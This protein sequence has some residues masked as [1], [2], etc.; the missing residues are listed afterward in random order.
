MSRNT[1]LRS[2]KTLKLDRALSGGMGRQILIYAIVVIATFSL[3][4]GIAI[5]IGIPV[6]EKTEKFGDFWKMLFYFYDGGL[7]GTGEKKWF[8]YLVNII[9]SILMGG[10]LIATITN[11]LLSNRD[12]AEM[13]LLRYRLSGHSAFIGC[14][15]SSIPLVKRVIKQHKYAVII[16]ELPVSEAKDKVISGLESDDL[17]KQ[18]ELR[19]QILELDKKLND[20][21]MMAKED[22]EDLKKRREDCKEELRTC[23]MEFQALEDAISSRLIVYHGLRTDFDE[24]KSL[25]LDDAE[26]VFVFPDSTLSNT[27][28]TNLEVVERLSLLCEGRGDKL[29]C[30]ALF[31]HNAVVSCFERSDINAQIK[32]RL[33]FSPVVYGDA[34]SRALLSGKVYGNQPLDRDGITEDSDQ[35]VHLFIIG[36]G[37]IG[38]A[39]FSE[40]VRQLHFPNFDKEKSTITLVGEQTE[41]DTAKR[42]YREYFALADHSPRYSYLGDILDIS[43]QMIPLGNPQELDSA[44]DRAIDNPDKLVTVAVCLEDSAMALEQTVSLSRCVFE[45]AIPIW[46]YKTD[47]D[48]LAKL[49]GENSFYS[50]IHLFGEPDKLFENDEREL[51]L[52]RAKR[53]NL[54]YKHIYDSLKKNKTLP[55]TLPEGLADTG[56][57]DTEWAGL[58]FRKQM[59]NL[60]CAYFI[61]VTERARGTGGEEVVLTDEQIDL[62]SRV[63]HNRWMA[64]TLISGFR[65]PFSEE[66][67]R[68]KKERSKEKFKKEKYVHL[69]LCS[70]EDLLPNDDG[71]DVREFDRGTVI[72]FHLIY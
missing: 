65:P 44:L 36:L 38:Q 27:D 3:L 64:E 37:E 70:S 52:R 33:D 8:I 6:S 29:K 39:L 2:T 41:I 31:Q 42:R 54:V 26:E 15:D 51:A 1:H 71:I 50:N 16:S 25:C 24:L 62:F 47:S 46:L 18:I 67:E 32:N 10:I 66:K 5:I 19:K 21:A 43:V 13:G 11:F 53:I 14:H 17:K 56:V 22:P 35:S 23:E 69:D 57:L 28:S 30:T 72:F 7:E 58:S 59:S 40:A 45:K 20:P 49:I 9:G 12:K 34:I 63:E 55:D 48:S 61:P 68:I 4:F 60:N